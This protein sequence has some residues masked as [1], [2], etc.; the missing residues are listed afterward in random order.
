[1]SGDQKVTVVLLPDRTGVVG[2]GSAQT[3]GPPPTYS[4]G[5]YEYAGG[6]I[7][8]LPTFGYTFTIFTTYKIGVNI[9][10]N[11]AYGRGTVEDDKNTSLQ[12]HESQHGFFIVKY[13]VDHPLPKAAIHLGMSVHEYK[14]ALKAF[15]VQFKKYTA[16][17]D[18]QNKINVDCVGTL[19]KKGYSKELDSLCYKR[20][21]NKA[22]RR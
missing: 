13:L 20:I 21:P 14:T 10:N 16:T 17:M 6:K 12:F 11:S 1:N 15:D 22:K 2:I 5:E 8:R 3:G 7:T 19:P 4:I 9:Q 18:K